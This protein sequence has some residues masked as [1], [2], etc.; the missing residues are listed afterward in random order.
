MP[1][2]ASYTTLALKGR[3]F[4][5]EGAEYTNHRNEGFYINPP[6]PRSAFH[7]AHVNDRSPTD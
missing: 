4:E 1:K 3:D 6:P 5:V 7:T 2:F